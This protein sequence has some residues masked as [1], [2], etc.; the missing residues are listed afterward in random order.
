[1]VIRLAS[2][3]ITLAAHVCVVQAKAKVQADAAEVFD[4]DKDPVKWFYA[5]Q[6]KSEAEFMQKKDTLRA[7]ARKR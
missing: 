7:A 3:G 4:Y 6:I 1:M 5:N 2:F